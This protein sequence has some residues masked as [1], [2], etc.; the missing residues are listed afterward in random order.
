MKTL[1]SQ[2]AQ[3]NTHFFLMPS[4]IGFALSMIVHLSFAA[5]FFVRFHNIDVQ[6]HGDHITT[7]SLATFQAPS[8][9][10][11]VENP[12]PKPIVHKKRHHH[13]EIVKEEGKLAKQEEVQPTP[14]SKAPKAKPDEKKEEGEIVQTL[15]YKDGDDD[16]VFAKIKRAIDRKN[17]YPSIA[18]KRGLEGEVVVEFVIY[19]DGRVADVRVSKACPHDPFNV[20][21]VNAVK[22][23]QADFPTL[24]VTTKIEIPIVYQLEK[25]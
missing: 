15:S 10:E 9:Q 17:K 25:S 6:Q 14:E 23:A 21:A 18:R 3:N 13:K 7:I 22:K 4:V 16:E 8:N 24:S 20:A 2:P 1:P 12:K 5:V 19:R 11:D